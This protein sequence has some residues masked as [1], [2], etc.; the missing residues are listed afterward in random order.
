MLPP[1][2]V[3]LPGNTL[4]PTWRICSQISWGKL[5][6]G[7]YWFFLFL[8]IDRGSGSGQG[9]DG[10]EVTTI[11]TY[12]KA[13]CIGLIWKSFS[14]SLQEN[15]NE[16]RQDFQVWDS[17]KI[18][19]RAENPQVLSDHVRKYTT[20]KSVSVM[21]NREH[22]NSRCVSY[23]DNR[24]IKRIRETYRIELWSW[25]P[26]ESEILNVLRREQVN[27]VV[28]TWVNESPNYLDFSINRKTPS[29]QV[30]VTKRVSITGDWPKTRDRTIVCRYVIRDE[31]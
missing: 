14:F 30:T 22:T 1:S 27:S 29:Y 24:N 3:A 6:G 19:T 13:L 17:H 11:T 9:K 12:L 2:F 4:R 5:K 16:S 26:F 15:H 18:A 8:R 31:S 10:R 20:E 28:E 23:M 21:D 25:S 7:G